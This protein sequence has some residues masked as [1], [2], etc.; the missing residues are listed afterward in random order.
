MPI[1]ILSPSDRSCRSGRADPLQE[2]AVRRLQID[3]HQL[4]AVALDRDVLTRDPVV[5]H[6]DVG[7][8]AAPEDRAVTLELVHLAEARPRDHHEV[9]ARPLRRLPDGLDSGETLVSFLVGGARHPC[10]C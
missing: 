1:E 9:G 8:I 7:A 6:P 3:E 5:D 10:P 2:R 4:A